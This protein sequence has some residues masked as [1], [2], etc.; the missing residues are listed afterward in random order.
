MNRNNYKQM[1]YSKHAHL[2]RKIFQPDETDRI[3]R[4]IHYQRFHSRR[5]AFTNGCFDILHAG[6]IDYLSRAAD[7]ADVLIVGLN[8][9]DSVRRIKGKNRPVNDQEAR[10]SLLAALSFVDAVVL[11]EEDTPA[12]LISAILPDV[13]IKGDDWAADDIVGADVVRKHNGRV[14]T[15]PLLK[16]YSTSNLIQKIKESLE[17]PE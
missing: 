5:I 7:E 8:T 10:A 3:R 11:F 17:T 15:L 16:G 4:M 2:Q 6:H 13:L 1:K 12:Q 9:D 14:L